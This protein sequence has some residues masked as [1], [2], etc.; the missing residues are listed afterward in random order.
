MSLIEQLKQNKEKAAAAAAANALNPVAPNQPTVAKPEAS[1]EHAMTT[2][3]R[4]GEAAF[5][6]FHCS[7]QECLGYAASQLMHYQLLTHKPDL[8]DDPTKPTQTLTLGV[9]TL[10]LVITGNRLNL[11]TAALIAGKLTAVRAIPSRYAELSSHQPFVAKIEPKALK[12]D[13]AQG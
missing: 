1:V 8:A 10:D 13:H 3:I 4:P 12:S 7:S 5:I 2:S 6:E 11:I 9:Q